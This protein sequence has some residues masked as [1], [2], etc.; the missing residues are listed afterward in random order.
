M[1]LF[2]VP[3]PPRGPC[4]SGRCCLHQTWLSCV[5]GR[6][7]RGVGG[8]FL[9]SKERRRQRKAALAG[10]RFSAAATGGQR[11]GRGHARRT[12][13]ILRACLWLCRGACDYHSERQGGRGA[14][15]FPFRGQARHRRR[16]QLSNNNVDRSMLMHVSATLLTIHPTPNTAQSM[17]R[18]PA[19]GDAATAR[20]RTKKQAAAPSS[21]S[22]SSPSRGTATFSLPHPPTDPLPSFG[23]CTRAA[24]A[25]D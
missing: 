22:P 7:G 17:A 8:G 12:G 21:S 18:S 11:L 15:S 1:P 2:G 23:T 19:T 14:G 25:W 13:I 9:Q 6:G 4:S 3:G 20:N 16:K 10:Q 24:Y 5:V